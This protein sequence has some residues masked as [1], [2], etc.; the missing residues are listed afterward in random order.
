MD[1]WNRHR[2]SE[3][4][5]IHEIGSG[6]KLLFT[7]LSLKV[8]RHEERERETQSFYADCFYIV[9]SQP[10]Q[11]A[12]PVA[13]KFVWPRLALNLDPLVRRQELN[14]LT[15]SQSQ[16]PQHTLPSMT[17]LTSPGFAQLWISTLSFGGRNSTHWLFPNLKI[18]SPHF[19]A[20]RHSHPQVPIAIWDFYFNIC[21]WRILPAHPWT[22]ACLH[23]TNPC[24]EPKGSHPN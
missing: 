7:F 9:S 20:W 24:T 12:P 3:I 5:N 13:H 18:L 21:E 2:E 22:P 16:N 14:S 17:S 15:F 10:N 23:L 11:L 1:M 6:T 4:H 8:I 19:R